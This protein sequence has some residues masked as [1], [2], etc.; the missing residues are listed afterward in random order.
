MLLVIVTNGLYELCPKTESPELTD[1]QKTPS[2]SR[3]AGQDGVGLVRTS[4]IM[5]YAWR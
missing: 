1:G 5:C 3:E 4:N 2:R